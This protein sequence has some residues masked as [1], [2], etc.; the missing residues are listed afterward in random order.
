MRNN[1]I[2][3]LRKEKR[4]TL[5]ELARLTGLSAGYLCHLEKGSRSNPSLE[6][7]EKIAKALNK[8]VVEIFFIQF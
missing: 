6:V 8:S 3:I 2:E 4:I 5:A 1:R 7:M